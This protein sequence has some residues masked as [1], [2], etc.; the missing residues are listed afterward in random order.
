MRRLL[1]YV[2]THLSCFL[3]RKKWTRE[4]EIKRSYGVDHIWQLILVRLAPMGMKKN[5]EK[6]TLSYFFCFPTESSVN[7]WFYYFTIFFRLHH[8]KFVKYNKNCQSRYKRL[9]NTKPKPSQKKFQ[10]VKIL[11]KWQ[12][13]VN[14]GHTESDL[15]VEALT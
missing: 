13:F 11:P 10:T 3:L 7:R 6:W 2:L 15:G 4:R 8:W 9:Q 12:N 14:S 1:D 5:G